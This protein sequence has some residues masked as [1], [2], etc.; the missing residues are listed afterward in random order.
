R[1]ET[2]L[3]QTIGRAARNVRG[4]VIMYA[5]KESAAMRR[6]IEETDRRR[7]IQRAYNQEHGITPETVQ[8]GIS[9]ITDFLAL[10]SKVPT[11]GRRTRARESDGMPLAEISR[12]IV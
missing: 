7:A 8:K 4:R 11:R 6:A 1:G 5:D 3:I 9:D 12:T 2:S 10:E